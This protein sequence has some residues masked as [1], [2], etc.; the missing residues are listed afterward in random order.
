MAIHSN[1][2][3]TTQETMILHLIER[4]TEYCRSHEYVYSEAYSK[5]H[6][7]R[8]SKEWFLAQ[9]GNP[10]VPMAFNEECKAEVGL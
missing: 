9:R 7:K 4:R 5:A 10:F 1:L 2:T 8:L 6:Q 3:R